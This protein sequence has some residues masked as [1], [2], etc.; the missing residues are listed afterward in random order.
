[1]KS[2]KKTIE[3]LCDEHGHIHLKSRRSIDGLSDAEGGFVS[4]FFD[5]EHEPPKKCRMLTVLF[6]LPHLLRGRLTTESSLMIKP[7][8]RRLEVGLESTW[9]EKAVSR[10][11]SFTP[12][13]L[14]L[15][16]QLV[17]AVRYIHTAGVA[18]GDWSS[19]TQGRQAR[20]REDRFQ[21]HIHLP[22]QKAGISVFEPMG[23]LPSKTCCDQCCVSRRK[24]DGLCKKYWDVWMTKW[25]FPDFETS[26]S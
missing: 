3:I 6:F 12:A 2:W 25:G 15:V 1:M 23:G 24:N 10:D 18:R 7:G 26:R 19:S 22:R 9:I 13:E 21:K 20:S 17:L 5:K 16:A 14:S 4:L 11:A 8:A